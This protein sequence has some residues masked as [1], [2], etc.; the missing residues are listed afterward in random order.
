M[1]V[2]DGG[3]IIR[4]RTI[5]RVPDSDKWNADQIMKLVATSRRPNP[6]DKDQE[7]ANNIRDTKGIDLGTVDPSSLRFPC[8]STKKY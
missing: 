3:P 8:A 4:V 5:I 7:E 6:G 1:A 2:M